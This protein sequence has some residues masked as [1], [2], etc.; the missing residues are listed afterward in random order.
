MKLILE[1]E[2]MTQLTPEELAFKEALFKSSLNKNQEDNDVKDSVGKE[3]TN[4]GQDQI[5]QSQ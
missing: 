1:I 3:L 5:N 2:R 4:Y